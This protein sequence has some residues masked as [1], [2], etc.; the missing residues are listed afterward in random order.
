MIR[1]YN[2]K[3]VFGV[4][5]Q[6]FVKYVDFLIKEAKDCADQE[7]K[8]QLDDSI[9]IIESLPETLS[10]YLDLI[11]LQQNLDKNPYSR[12]ASKKDLFST[13]YFFK[14]R[15]QSDNK[16]LKNLHTELLYLVDVKHLLNI[17]RVDFYLSEFSK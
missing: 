10:N 1:R 14:E 8:N 13:L 5:D 3:E 11:Y 12:W 7:I 15:I 16:I 4:N 2:R 6:S 17:K 9:F